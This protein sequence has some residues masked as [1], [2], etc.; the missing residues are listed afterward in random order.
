MLQFITAPAFRYCIYLDQPVQLNKIVLLK[1]YVYELASSD[2]D[3]QLSDIVVYVNQT[4]NV[5]D[6]SKGRIAV[7]VFR[8]FSDIHTVGPEYDVFKQRI[9]SEDSNAPLPPVIEYLLG[10]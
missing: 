9:M 1:R 6:R 3:I 2:R 5:Q 4:P 10:L 8:D 7:Y